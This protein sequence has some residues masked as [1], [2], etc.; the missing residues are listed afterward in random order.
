MPTYFSPILYIARNMYNN[1]FNIITQNKIFIPSKYNDRIQ[2]SA[3][4]FDY[5]FRYFVD[6]LQTKVFQ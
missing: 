5:K 4:Y 6:H 1:K 3:P 2:L